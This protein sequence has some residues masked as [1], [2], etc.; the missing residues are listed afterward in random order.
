MQSAYRYYSEKETE[1]KANVF[2]YCHAGRRS[3]EL[4]DGLAYEYL[5][6][7]AIKRH[8]KSILLLQLFEQQ[9]NICVLSVLMHITFTGT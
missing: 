2:T 9:S 3:L 1:S 8:A 5:H 4:I 6:H 7:Y